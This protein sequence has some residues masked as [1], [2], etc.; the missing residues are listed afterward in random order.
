MKKAGV[1]TAFFKTNKM[2]KTATEIIARA[3]LLID[4]QVT[5]IDDAAS[6]E[7]SITDMARSILPEVSRD[8]VK[9]LPY[10]LKRY[11]SKSANL[12]VG[13]LANG[14]VQSNYV[15]K[16]V[17][18]VAPTDFWELVAIRMTVWAKT[19]TSY[20]LIDSEEYTIQNN[21]F[22]RGGKQNPVVA[23]SNQSSGS[24][25]RI[26]CFSVHNGDSTNVDVF[27]YISFDNV[28]DDVGN[29]WPDQLF[30]AVTKALASQLNLIKSRTDEAAIRGE[31]A[32][33]SI[34]NH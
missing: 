21:P 25:A 1:Y 24:G 15:K 14:E 9:E 5:D 16:K 13:N 6:T 3:L 18:F 17:A 27:Q 33:K 10:E 20:I 28:P 31:E 4:E 11:L 34:E 2:S 30:D 23:I 7:M 8:L 32:I 29:P 19:V 12:T 22:T 26:E